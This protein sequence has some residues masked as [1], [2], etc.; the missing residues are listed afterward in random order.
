MVH[1]GDINFNRILYSVIGEDSD[2]G[3][4]EVQD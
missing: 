4:S 3:E 1:D 2:M